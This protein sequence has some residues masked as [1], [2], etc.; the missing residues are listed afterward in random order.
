[1]LFKDL[2]EVSFENAI[3]LRQKLCHYFSYSFENSY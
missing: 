3:F 1:M 2:L